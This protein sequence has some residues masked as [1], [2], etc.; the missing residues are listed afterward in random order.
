M[1]P[2][3]FLSFVDAP[4]RHWCAIKNGQWRKPHGGLFVGSSRN[5]SIPMDVGEQH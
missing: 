3:S 2:A 5:I 4:L 1:I